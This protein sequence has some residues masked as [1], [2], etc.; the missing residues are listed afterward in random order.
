MKQLIELIQMLPEK[1]QKI[2]EVK[3]ICDEVEYIK[4]YGKVSHGSFLTEGKM[5]FK[6][7]EEHAQELEKNLLHYMNKI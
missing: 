2:Q 1:I 4:K 7:I 5:A 3:Y 6:N